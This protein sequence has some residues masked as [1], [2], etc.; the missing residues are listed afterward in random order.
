MSIDLLTFVFSAKLFNNI[1]IA[2]LTIGN[3]SVDVW[4][5]IRK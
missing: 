4:N 3:F 1:V 5:Y 2:N